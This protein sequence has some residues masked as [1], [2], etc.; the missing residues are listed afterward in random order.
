MWGAAEAPRGEALNKSCFR[1]SRGGLARL[2]IAFYSS[3]GTFCRTAVTSGPSNR[4]R[5]ADLAGLLDKLEEGDIPV[6]RRDH[7][8]PKTVREYIYSAMEDFRSDI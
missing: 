1:P 5:P 4:E 6:H 2:T 7:R 8:I 3:A